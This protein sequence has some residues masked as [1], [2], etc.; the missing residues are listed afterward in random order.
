MGLTE[1]VHTCLQIA[2]VVAQNGRRDARGLDR[3]FQLSLHDVLV[4]M[5]DRKQL[6]RTQVLPTQTF[7]RGRQVADAHTQH[8][9]ALLRPDLDGVIDDPNPIVSQFFRT[10]ELIQRDSQEPRASGSVLRRLPRDP[11]ELHDR[12]DDATGRPKSRAGL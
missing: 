7:A 8:H 10:F 2:P 6:Q 9:Q 1:A 4:R 5:R 12:P 11:K 3:V